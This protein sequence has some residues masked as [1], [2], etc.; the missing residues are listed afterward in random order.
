[1]KVHKTGT[2]LSILMPTALT[3]LI[4]NFLYELIPTPLEGLPIFFPLI[5]CPIGFI[6]AYISYKNGGSRWTKFGMV[7]NSVLFCTPFI[8][9]IGGTLLFGA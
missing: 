1:M 4:I 8:W 2:F 5:V 6:L 3:M 7:L 9:M